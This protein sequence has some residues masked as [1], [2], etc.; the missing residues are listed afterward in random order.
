MTAATD[1]ADRRPTMTLWRLELL[2]LVRTH[3]WMI[4]FG[5]YTALAVLSALTA[6][7]FNEIMERF[8]EG[9]EF[10]ATEPQPVDAII[11][12]V[13]N[14]SQIGVL[15]V[16]VVAASSLTIDAKPEQAAF[17]RT[18]VTRP[19]R[20]LVAPYTVNVAAACAAMATGTL[21]V[22]LLTEMLIGP[23]PLWRLVVGAFLGACYLAFAVAV[24][25]A[26]AGFTRGQATTVF[27]ALGVLLALPIIGLFEPIQAWLPS[28]LIS[29]LAAMVDGASVGEFARSL[30]VTALATTALLAIAVFRFERRE[31]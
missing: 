14:T 2:R 25:A 19:A 31:L 8:G 24:V 22:S 16:V 17:L 10:T 1:T 15:A 23:L 20:L 3:R 6:R 27:G 26:V 12:F 30:L 18:K 9:V 5:V 11:Q 29:G 4:L 7:Y 28:E 13:S 21:V